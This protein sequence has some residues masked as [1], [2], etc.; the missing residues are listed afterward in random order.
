[1]EDPVWGGCS[2]SEAGSCDCGREGGR[3][4]TER[5]REGGWVGSRRV[6]VQLAGE[7]GDRAR[8]PSASSLSFQGVRRVSRSRAGSQPLFPDEEAEAREEQSL[9]QASPA[10]QPR[11]DQDPRWG[12]GAP[13]P[14]GDSHLCQDTPSASAAGPGAKDRGR[15]PQHSRAQ[16][17]PP[18]RP[19]DLT[20]PSAP[21]RIRTPASAT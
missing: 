10:W 12:A 16:P 9:R 15:R 18:D 19:S 8:H 17:G 5:R 13:G 3:R 14:Y 4:R 11:R 2:G 7:E 20:S 1:M 6:C 21:P